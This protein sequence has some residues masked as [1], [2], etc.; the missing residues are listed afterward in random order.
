MHFRRV[1][2]ALLLL[3]LLPLVSTSC[4]VRRRSI[5]RKGGQINQ[6]LLVADRQSLIDA[7]ARQYETIRD[8]NAE[9]NMVPALGSTEKNRVT[10]YKDVRAYILFRK[11]A[12]IRL[13]GLYP[14]V[15][16]KAFDM[17]SDGMEFKLFVP[18]RNRFIV[19]KNEIDQPSAN[20]LENLRPQH[21]Q[22]AMLVKPV[23]AAADKLLMENFTDE[24]N[25]FYILEVIRENGNQQLQLTRTIWFNRTDLRL[26]RQLIFDN[27]GNILTDARYSDW[28]SYDNVPFPKH[29]EINRPRDEYAVVI[30][31][32]KM[33]INKGVGPEKFVL[34]QP[35][36]TTLQVLGQ[37]VTTPVTPP[38]PP[39]K[40]RI[41]KK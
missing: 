36:G 18:A 4:L 19:G 29:I 34:D 6:A 23:D 35:E 1:P 24:D 39:A 10:E 15:R 9:V 31:I 13:I 3:C 21:F 20:K 5:A 16:N 27:A 12:G 7:I 38:A 8:F 41:K 25:A 37:P 17:V 26:A 40:G 33:D 32:V 14:V 22:D 30:D 28:K 11:P 2:A